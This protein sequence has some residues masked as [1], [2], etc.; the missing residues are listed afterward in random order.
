VSG[1]SLSVL[2]V[3]LVLDKIAGRID[4]EDKDDDEPHFWAG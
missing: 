1:R 4:D 2:V 3:L